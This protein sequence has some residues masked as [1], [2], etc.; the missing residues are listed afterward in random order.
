MTYIQQ[1]L[2]NG[3]WRNSECECDTEPPASI[4]VDGKEL[5]LV[6]K[7]P[8][9]TFCPITGLPYPVA[10]YIAPPQHM[11]MKSGTKKASHVMDTVNAMLAECRAENVTPIRFSI[12]GRSERAGFKVKMMG[13]KNNE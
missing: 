10:L 2:F 3:I 12:E 5:R 11:E 4:R 8:S 6:A 7:Y 1:F 9:R 13:V